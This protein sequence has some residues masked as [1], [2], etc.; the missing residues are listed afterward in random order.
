MFVFILFSCSFCC[1]S[2]FKQASIDIANSSEEVC[3]KGFLPQGH[4]EISRS[5]AGQPI[6]ITCQTLSCCDIFLGDWE[7][8]VLLPNLFL[9]AHFD[10]VN[11]HSELVI[12]KVSKEDSGTYVCSAE[13]SVG[14][15]KAIG[16]VYVKGRYKCT[17]FN[18]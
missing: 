18:L 5:V 13:N 7:A 16:F 17:I 10:S 12:E 3:R 14:F 9:S 8:F 2:F 15:V 6:N 1:F 11:G 4:D